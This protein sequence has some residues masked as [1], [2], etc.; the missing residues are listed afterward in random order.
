M[1]VP[2][3]NL[4]GKNAKV[5]CGYKIDIKVL[6]HFICC[7]SFFFL[8]LIFLAF[9]SEVWFRG[10]KG[11]CNLQGL[12]LFSFGCMVLLQWITVSEGV[13]DMKECVC[14][15]ALR[16]SCNSHLISLPALCKFLS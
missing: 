2:Y 11:I 16:L 7:C 15:M 10:K 12:T 8:F 14:L 6:Y 4:T 5:S 1:P 3:D 9:S 13:L